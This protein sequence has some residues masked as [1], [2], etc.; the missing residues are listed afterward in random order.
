MLEQDILEVFSKF[1]ID[2]HNSFFTLI[3][4]PSINFSG[5]GYE[6]LLS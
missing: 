1:Y 4:R 6:I 2:S 5:L 3:L